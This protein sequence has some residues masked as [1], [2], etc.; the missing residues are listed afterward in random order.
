M[1]ISGGG[2]NFLSPRNEDLENFE[3]ITT[4]SKVEDVVKNTSPLAGEVEFVNT[5]LGEG[6]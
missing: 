4:Q 6:L 1:R 3:E 5:N 2:G